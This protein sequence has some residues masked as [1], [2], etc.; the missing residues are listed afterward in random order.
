VTNGIGGYASSTVIGANTRK[1]HGLLVASLNPPVEREV[2]LAKL[3]EELAVED[4]AY[5]LS[6]NL[7]PGA[8]HPEGFRHLT[9]FSP[10]PLPTFVYAVEGI[11]IE[12]TVFMVHGKN[13]AVVRYRV[14]NPE[15]RDLGFSIRPLVISRDFHSVI[16]REGLGWGFHE[17]VMDGGVRVTA[18]YEGAPALELLSDMEWEPSPLPEERRWYYNLEYPRERERG[19]DCH[20]DLYC[21]GTFTHHGSDGD[22]SFSI[23]AACGDPGAKALDPDAA[24]EREIKRRK[25]LLKPFYEKNNLPQNDAW[26]DL[27][28]AADAFIVQRRH[29]RG[30]SILAG[31]PWFSDWGRDA[32]IA[33][34]GLCLVPG[35]FEDAK[36]VLKTFAGSIRKGLVP[37]RFHDRGTGADYN[38][39]DAALWFVIAAKRYLDYTGDWGFAKKVLSPAIEKIVVGYSRGTDFDIFM[40][41]DGLLH[42]G[43]PGTQLTWMDAKVGDYVVTPRHGKAVEINALWYNALQIGAEILGDDDYLDL[44][45]RV[46]EGFSRFWN[47]GQ[48]CLFD[49]IDGTDDPSIR[50]NQVFAL[51]LPH[52]LLKRRKAK[53]V[54]AVVQ[55]RLLTPYGLRTLSPDDS[56][57]WGR[58][59]GGP[60]ERDSAYHQG[61]VWPWLVGPFVTAY[62]RVKGR[63]EADGFLRP[64]LD[65]MEGP[66]S[67]MIP[68]IFDGDPPH[69]PRGCIA[70]A[71]STAEV[72]RAYYE[73]VLEMVPQK[74]YVRN[75]N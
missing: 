8:V 44:A 10:R 69:H 18:G 67:G 49:V 7:Y 59:E 74:L 37:N 24:L 47:P 48:K 39:V 19:Y 63:G 65:Y 64:L 26:D 15:G 5:S 17:E 55:D 35:R 62:V 2:L 52:I 43:N 33:L 42:A 3:E 51:S 53:M 70:Q 50:P 66:G 54:L 68:E 22:I 27:I 73:D 31:Y 25:T 29:P 14:S 13:T 23:V 28:L 20:D 60:L 9:D 75:K 11:R 56:R 16:R 72:L 34:P 6:T 58:Y 57:Y 41:T 30:Q 46:R 1:Y 12:K 32:M 4:R 61:T 40:D 38:T 21:P 71:W 36:Q 45:K